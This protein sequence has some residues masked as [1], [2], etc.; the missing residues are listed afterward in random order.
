VRVIGRTSAAVVPA[1]APVLRAVVAS[2]AGVGFA[3]AAHTSTEHGAP[4]GWLIALAVLGCLPLT[5]LLTRREVRLPTLLGGL[6]GTQ[7]ALHAAFLLETASRARTAGSPGWLC[8]GG[9]P[10][11]PGPAVLDRAALVQLALHLVVAVALAALLRCGERRLWSVARAA[12]AHAVGSVRALVRQLVAQLSV[13]ATA[14][15]APPRRPRP[16]PSA[17][18]PPAL[19]AA[20]PHTRRGPPDPLPA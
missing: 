10:A 1:P 8:C 20:R 15:P 19:V 11:H 9:A 4:P 17:A 5:A 18:R 6:V 7:L 14:T 16:Q 13:A 12:A 3:L 2:T